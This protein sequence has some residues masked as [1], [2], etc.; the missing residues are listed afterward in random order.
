MV[1]TGDRAAEEQLAARS[2]MGLA[3]NLMG[4]FPGKIDSGEVPV[5]FFN[6]LLGCLR[7]NRSR[8]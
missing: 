5:P 4:N 6:G 7:C 1:L 3:P 2:K 8:L